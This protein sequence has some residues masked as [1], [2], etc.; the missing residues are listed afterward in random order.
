MFASIAVTCAVFVCS[1]EVLQS[2]SQWV[3]YLSKN[4][5]SN[6]SGSGLSPFSH[7]E[8]APRFK[9]PLH[10]CIMYQTRY[11]TSYDTLT[12]TS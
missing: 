9:I 11:I 2:Q 6:A 1:I 10:V 8:F 3:Q 4:E 5:R 7:V 12:L